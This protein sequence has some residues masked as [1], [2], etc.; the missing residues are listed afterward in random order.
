[1]YYPLSAPR[2]VVTQTTWTHPLATQ[3]DPHRVLRIPHRPQGQLSLL[4]RHVPDV[5]LVS[6]APEQ[7]RVDEQLGEF[8]LVEHCHD[9]RQLD[10][11]KARRRPRDEPSCTEGSRDW[12]T[13]SVVWYPVFSGWVSSLRH[14]W[15]TVKHTRHAPSTRSQWRAHASRASFA[16]CKRASVSE[17]IGVSGE[18]VSSI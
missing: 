14:M 3:A 5:R 8:S 7:L 12:R 17:S 11:E 13:K 1:V 2:T 4:G 6:D 16:C 15:S 18:A 10:R 9:A